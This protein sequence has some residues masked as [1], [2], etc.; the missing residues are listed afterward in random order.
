MYEFYF[1]AYSLAKDNIPSVLKAQAKSYCWGT[2][3]HQEKD[4]RFLCLVT[5]HGN[6]VCECCQQWVKGLTPFTCSFQ[7]EGGGS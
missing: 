5:H 2:I 7:K 6:A 3:L 4:H 1:L